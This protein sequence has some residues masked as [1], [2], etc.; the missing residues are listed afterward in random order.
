M[1]FF[2]LHFWDTFVVWR[3]LC[4]R[5]DRQ[6]SLLMFFALAWVFVNFKTFAKHVFF[7]H[8]VKPTPYMSALATA[9]LKFVS[10]WPFEAGAGTA[11]TL[12]E[13][14]GF[15]FE[16]HLKIY[17]GPM[18]HFASGFVRAWLRVWQM[19]LGL[20][21]IFIRQ[22]CLMVH[23]WPPPAEPL[24]LSWRALRAERR[25]PPPSPRCFFLPGRLTPSSVSFSGFTSVHLSSLPSAPGHT[26]Q[27]WRHHYITLAHNIF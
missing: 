18:K 12:T 14:T 16:G 20:F 4:I 2:F 24:Q 15:G 22:S 21:C 11:R 6:I 3:V 23:C 13:V 5:K 9:A 17:C 27:Q 7:V 1:M 10:E 19:H 8:K 25:Y 26:E